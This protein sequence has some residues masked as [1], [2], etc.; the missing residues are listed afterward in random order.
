MS[1]SNGENT[2]INGFP[3]HSKKEKHLHIPQ[4]IFMKLLTEVFFEK[5]S[6]AC[7]FMVNTAFIQ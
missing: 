2:K 3:P 1:V 6:Q 7:L 4:G 5:L